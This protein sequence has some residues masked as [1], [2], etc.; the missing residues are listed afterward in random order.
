[1]LDQVYHTGE[2]YLGSET[3]LIVVNETGQPITTCF[4][5]QAHREQGQ[6]LGIGVFAYDVTEK[7]LAR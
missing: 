7:V 2:T 6:L 1:M 5:F 4:T 3:Q